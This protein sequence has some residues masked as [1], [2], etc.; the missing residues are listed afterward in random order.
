MEGQADRETDGGSG[1]Q[2][3][4]WKVRRKENMDIQTN[5]GREADRYGRKMSGKH[6]Y[7]NIE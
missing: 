7:N 6:S 1:G 4:R 3:D 5:G 2:I